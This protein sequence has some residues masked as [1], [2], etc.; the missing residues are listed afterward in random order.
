MEVLLFLVLCVVWPFRWL[1]QLCSS[2]SMAFQKTSATPAHVCSESLRKNMHGGLL[3]ASSRNYTDMWTRDTFFASMGIESPR[4]FI[5]TLARYQREDGLVPLY[6]GRGNACCKFLCG[7]RPSGP[8]KATY[9]DVKTGDCPTD[10]CF[11]FIIM[12][13]EYYPAQCKKAWA[14]MQRFVRHGLVYEEGLGTWQ[15]TIKHVGHVAYTNMLYYQATKLLYPEKAPQ[16]RAKLIEALWTGTH[17]RCSSTNDSFG[18]VDNALGLLYDVAP[19]ASA[20][21]RTFRAYFKSPLSPPNKRLDCADETAFKW[22]D[23]FLPCYP[24]G[25]ARYHNGW[26]WS[27]P[28]L[29]MQKALKKCGEHVDVEALSS[30]ISKYGTLYETYD[31]YGPVKRLL[32]QSQPD[33]SEACGLYLDVVSDK[34]H[35]ALI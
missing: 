5:D 7:A 11:Q 24:L 1:F 10:S 26:A 15:D 13:H 30:W 17:F 25:N 16:I 6:V 21:I 18:Q 19:R 31:V 28:W 20:V 23:V 12:A 2:K 3:W 34:L 22:S 14:F 8:V 32:Y 4:A 33:F 29:L 27:W 35:T 9:T